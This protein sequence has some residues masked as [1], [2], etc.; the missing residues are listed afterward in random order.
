ML[1]S[2]FYSHGKLLLTSEYVVLDG[3]CALGLPTQKGQSLSV[4]KIEKPIINWRSFDTEGKKWFLCQLQFEQNRFVSADSSQPETE[5]LIAIFNWIFQKNPNLFDDKTGFQFD[6]YLEFPQNWGLGSSSTLINNLAQWAKIDAFEMQ[7]FAFGGSGYDI[8]C[9]QHSTPILFQ[10]FNNN[11]KVREV[12]FFPEFHQE[13]FF[14]HLNKKQNSREAI[15]HYR[16]KNLIQIEGA[17]ERINQITEQLL[18]AKSISVFEQLINSHEKIIASLLEVPPVKQQ[19]FPDYPRSIKS[20]GGWGGD[21]VLATGSFSEM[22]Y[23]KEKGF[24]TIISYQE[25]ILND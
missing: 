18:T 1:S 14:V 16:G 24:S 3:A 23:F 5:K 19:L 11:I 10:N 12:D 20:L 17:V 13:L 15:A 7:D 6:S 21:F 8:A 22:N 2:E 25:M 4:S 9:A